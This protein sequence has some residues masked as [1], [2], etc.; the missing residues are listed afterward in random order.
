[1]GA[2]STTLDFIQRVTDLKNWGAQVIVDDLGFLV[3]P[4]FEDGALATAY[5]NAVKQG[6]V[7]VSAAGNAALGHYQAVGG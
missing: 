4:Y 7:I 2:V 5:A 3:Q 6:V 1:M